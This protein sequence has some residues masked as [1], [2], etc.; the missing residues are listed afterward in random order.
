M[1]NSLKR[2]R[3][4][5]HID[6]DDGFFSRGKR[7]QMV[8]LSLLFD[9]ITMLFLLLCSL[10]GKPTLPQFLNILFGLNNVLHLYLAKAI[11]LRPHTSR[12]HWHDVIS[13]GVSLSYVFCM[14]LFLR[15]SDNSLCERRRRT[16]V[17]PS[18]SY[19]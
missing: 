5:Q 11:R 15:V 7:C 17:S 2:G 8:S 9:D 16:Y 19:W 13:N 6:D 10:K 12:F 14:P 1:S 18:G 3:P 4:N